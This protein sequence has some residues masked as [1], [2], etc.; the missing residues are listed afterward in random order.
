MCFSI[1]FLF[2]SFLRLQK[3]LIVFLLCICFR[4]VRWCIPLI[5]LILNILIIYSLPHPPSIQYPTHTSPL[6][7]HPPPH[8]LTTIH[9]EYP[10]PQPSPT[11]LLI[12]SHPPALLFIIL[13]IILLDEFILKYFRWFNTSIY[14][15]W[16]S[17]KIHQLKSKKSTN[18]NLK[19]PPTESL[20]QLHSEEWFD[21][22]SFVFNGHWTTF[23]PGTRSNLGYRTLL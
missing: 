7:Q 17:S 21:H 15:V 12:I 6:T 11:L 22:S 18:L 4:F 3:F 10:S 19:N 20:S 9:T 13:N 8:P 14:S 1:F 16:T 2:L 5:I 23:L